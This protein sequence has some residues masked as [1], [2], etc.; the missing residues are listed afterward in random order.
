M[1]GEGSSSAE[2]RFAYHDLDV[3]E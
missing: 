2:K 1:A 3:F